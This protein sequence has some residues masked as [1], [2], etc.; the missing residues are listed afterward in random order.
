MAETQEFTSKSTYDAYIKTLNWKN[1][2][3][4]K[5]EKYVTGYTGPATVVLG[6][7]DLPWG[8]GALLKN[9]IASSI[10]NKAK[11]Q[12]ATVMR[13][14]FWSNTA[15]ILDDKY[16]VEVT[17]HD[18]PVVWWVVAGIVLGALAVLG[19]VISVMWLAAA[20]FRLAGAVAEN[21]V[22]LALIAAGTIGL[23]YL[24]SRS[25]GGKHG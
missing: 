23:V 8:I 15:G 18:S 5:D 13:V 14:R 20:M 1:Y 19:L 4:D 25:E 24:I 16:R 3:L 11:D 6:E 12:G 10:V 9:K 17:A 7:F 22:P 21:I 2:V